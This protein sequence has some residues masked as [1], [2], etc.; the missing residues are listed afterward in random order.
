MAHTFL[1]LTHD[2]TT[3][4]RGRRGKDLLRIAVN[5]AMGCL[6]G[7]ERDAQF[8]LVGS[9]T[10]PT[11]ACSAILIGADPTG[12][13]GGVVNGVTLTDTWATSATVS[14]GLVAAAINAS[15]NALVQHVVGATNLCGK[16]T[17][18]TCIAGTTIE[19]GGVRF[20]AIAG[21]AGAIPEKSGDFV[22]S[23]TNTEDGTSLCGAINRHPAASRWFF[24]LNIAGACYVFIKSAAYFTGPNIPS[25]SLR[26]VGGSGCTI[27]T[28]TFAAGANCGVYAKLPGKWGNHITIAAS[29]GNVTIENSNTRLT[30]GLGGDAAPVTD[31]T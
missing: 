21:T 18:A 16:L 25:N 23:G 17:L 26:T 15:T 14:A 8:T 27:N 9:G 11:F 5:K 30:R 13:V 12:A 3:S 31:N 7:V 4:Q 28:A 24:A 10:D 6:G 19:I 1:M 2:Q 29:G 20:T 22:I